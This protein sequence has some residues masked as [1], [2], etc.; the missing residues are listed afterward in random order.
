MSKSHLIAEIGLFL[1]I[2]RFFKITVANLMS[3]SHSLKTLTSIKEP[4]QFPLEF[5]KVLTLLEDEPRRDLLTWTSAVAILPSVLKTWHPSDESWLCLG[6]LWS[7]LPW[8]KHL[9]EPEVHYLLPFR[10]LGVKKHATFNLAVIEEKLLFWSLK[11][12]DLWLM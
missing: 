4:C 11:K 2:W 10:E 12:V 7:S 3:L 5:N 8:D 6:V 1:W 9:L